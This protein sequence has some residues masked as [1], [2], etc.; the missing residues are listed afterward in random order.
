MAILEER[1]VVETDSCYV[2]RIVRQREDDERRP[3]EPDERTKLD[4]IRRQL[5]RE[6]RA[7]LRAPDDDV[8]DEPPRPAPRPRRLT[9]RRRRSSLAV[10]VVVAALVVV[11]LAVLALL[12]VREGADQ[13]R[14]MSALSLSG[15]SGLTRWASNPASVARRRSAG[16]P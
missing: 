4:E 14:A 15:S 9:R 10:T 16:W 7:S 8:D 2:S 12:A 3:L 11:V 5:E 1:I 13:H 6:W